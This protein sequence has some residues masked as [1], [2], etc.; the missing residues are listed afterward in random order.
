MKRAIVVAAL[1]AALAGCANQRP[2]VRVEALADPA[3]QTMLRYALY[4]GNEGVRA[5]DL[6]FRSYGEQVAN[7]MS[8]RGYTLVGTPE[9]ADIFVFLQYST[10]GPHTTTSTSAMP[11][12]GQTGY[13]SSQTYGTIGA[14]GNYS[15]T[16]N[17][18]PTYG[19]TGYM[20]ITNTHTFY[21]HAVRLTAY[22]NP[23]GSTQPQEMWNVSGSAISSD[24]DLPGDFWAFMQTM[25][26]YIGTS[27]RA[28][29]VPVT[30]PAR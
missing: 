24:G 25:G 5:T 15:A 9:Q 18:T 23:R 16:T 29:E 10:G 30:L 28:I 22:R 6:Q 11:M 8:G 19:V 2:T 3:S 21:V 27:Q 26:P 20:P 14:G 7:T 1:A 17:Y 12:W 13:S 4:P